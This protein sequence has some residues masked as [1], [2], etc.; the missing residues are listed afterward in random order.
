M[1]AGYADL[2]VPEGRVRAVDTTLALLAH[3]DFV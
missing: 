1:D 2:E 3:P